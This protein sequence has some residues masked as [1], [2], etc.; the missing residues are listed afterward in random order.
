MLTNEELS[1]KTVD[2]DVRVAR[3]LPTYYYRDSQYFELARE[4]V[5]A[6]SW[7][8]TTDTD[9]LKVPGQAIPHT[10]MEGYL[11]E[12]IVLTRD[13]T[14]QIHCMSN[15]C[16]HRGNL[17]VEG[18]CHTQQLRCRYHGRRFGLDGKFVST[19]GFEDAADFPS[20]EDDLPRVPVGQWSKFIFSSIDPAYPLDDLIGDMQK[21]L[22]WLPLDQFI[23]DPDNSRDYLVQ[24]N[25]A[26]YVENYLEGF[27]V[28]YVHPDLAVLLDTKSYRTELHKNCNVQVG[29]AQRAEDAFDLPKSSPDYGQSIAAYYYWLFPNTMFNFY[30]W[31]LSINI[32]VPLAVNRTRIRF[33]TYVY[34]KSRMAGYSIAGIDKT[35]REDENIVEQVQ[36]GIASRFYKRGR[37]SPQ[38]ETGVH[39]FHTLLQTALDGE[40]R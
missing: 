14:D 7:Q 17:L 10:A 32:V 30:P 16:T 6:R 38:W 4:R 18:E 5:F 3:T 25:W 34:D 20:K 37:Y 28:P 22:S 1:R 12:P 21:R 40:A 19:P 31:G 23:F 13:T 33:L 36:K 35:E 15:V 9:R 11:N 24:A 26:L 39:H 27:H 8:F 2:P 29:I